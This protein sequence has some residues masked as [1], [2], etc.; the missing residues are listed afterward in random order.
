[1]EGNTTTVGGSGTDQNTA[2]DHGGGVYVQK[3]IF[4]MSGGKITGNQ[5]RRGGGVSGGDKAE[6]VVKG[7]SEISENTATIN[8]TLAGGG[9]DASYTLTVADTAQIKQNHAPNGLGGGIA[10]GNDTRFD[11]SGGTVTGNT[12]GYY[13][14]GVYISPFGQDTYLKMSG[15]AKVET[16]NDMFLS[17]STD[18]EYAYITVTGAL[19]QAS[20]AKLTMNNSSGYSV[21]RAVVKGDGGYTLT[22]EDTGRF[23][24]TPKGTQNWYIDSDGKL[25]TTQPSP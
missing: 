11:F 12:A 14:K 4:T 17:G 13:G 10:C 19:K 9:I 18:G 2:A 23:T 24:V 21:G 6:I 8:G 7:S 3:G 1:M 20:T 5:A 15:S 16:N 25:T 22:A